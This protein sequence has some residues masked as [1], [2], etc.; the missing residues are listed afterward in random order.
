M[1]RNIKREED[2][3][4]H[5]TN[6]KYPYTIAPK[7]LRRFLDL[8]PTKPKPPKVTIATLKTWGFKSSND[9]TILRVL[10][11]IG[12]LGSSGETTEEYASYMN[13]ITGAAALG[14]L[15]RE[16]YEKLFQNVA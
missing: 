7:A 12:L 6:P 1:P 2:D 10:K 11:A 9:T 5:T 16:T 4:S 3:G 15:V 14:R 8:V 13:P